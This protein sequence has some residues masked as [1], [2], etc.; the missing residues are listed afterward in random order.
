MPVTLG[1]AGRLTWPLCSLASSLAAL[2]CSPPGVAR[3]DDPPSGSQPMAYAERPLTLP[4]LTLSPSVEAIVDKLSTAT[5]RA[6]TSRTPR[7]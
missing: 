4:A 5:P 3:A 6:S 7:T 2:A 1:T